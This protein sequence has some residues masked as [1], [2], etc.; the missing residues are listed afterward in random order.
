MITLRLEW[1]NQRLVRRT[2]APGPGLLTDSILF[3]NSFREFQIVA[4]YILELFDML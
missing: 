3:K 4:D 1:P 2:S